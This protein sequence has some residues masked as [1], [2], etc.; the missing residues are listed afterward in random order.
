MIRQLLRKV[1]KVKIVN[2]AAMGLK[3]LRAYI[4]LGTTFIG[5]FL[6]QT[7]AG[8]C[9]TTTSGIKDNTEFYYFS[10]HKTGAAAFYNPWS[11]VIEGGLGALHN[12]KLENFDLQT[13]GSELWRQLSNPVDAVSQYGTRKF[14]Y[15]EF[16][17]HLGKG[18]NF[19]PNYWWHLIG[20]GFRNK[21]MEEYY[22]YNGYTYPKT[23]A[24]IT[25]YT[26]HFINEYVQAERF[27]QLHEQGNA[28]VDDN[29]VVDALPDLLFFDWVGKIIFSYDSVNRFASNKFHL[30]DW[31]YQTQY[32]PSTVRLLNN[33]QLFWARLKVYGPFGI[34]ALT[35]EQIS[36]GNITV[37]VYQDYQ[38]SLG[39]GAKPKTFKVDSS[40]NIDAES[41][42]L[43][44]G[45][46]LSK[47]DSPIVVASY[48][49]AEKASINENPEA[50]NE[51][52]DKTIINIYPGLYEFYGMR[53]GFTFSYQKEAYF[54]GISISGWPAGLILST[55][56]KQKYLDAL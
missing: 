4:L 28:D 12:K 49:M 29:W 33:G 43:N 10:P 56:Q 41:I 40:G 19:A 9:A 34:S 36:T 25:L 7:Q 18:R 2:T 5:L 44:F 22:R 15:Y 54:F 45:M 55:P 23:M 16:I 52:T 24:W 21:L 30:R 14:F 46:Y 6:F 38:F 8:L 3:P 53:P 47:N 51:Y 27:Y 42:A 31:S 35:G 50:I 17:P 13:G 26:M 1:G 48:E 11:M 37:D 20:G 39:F 32:N